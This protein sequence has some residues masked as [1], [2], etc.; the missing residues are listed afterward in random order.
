MMMVHH[1]RGS[2]TPL[3]VKEEKQLVVA[4]LVTPRY[5]PLRP[6]HICALQVLPSLSRS[7]S[8]LH[9]FKDYLDKSHIVLS[10]GKEKPR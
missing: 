10:R 7:F 4:F 3:G 8:L 5:T 2:L 9:L 1:V 6:G